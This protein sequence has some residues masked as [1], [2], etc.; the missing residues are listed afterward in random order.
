MKLAILGAGC[1]RT[2]A[3]SGI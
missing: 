1:Y 3:A 2:D